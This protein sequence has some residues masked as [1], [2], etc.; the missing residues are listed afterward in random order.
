MIRDI[1]SFGLGYIE[2][3]LVS[4]DTSYITG[5]LMTPVGNY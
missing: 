3:L 5:E 4:L 2:Y 1:I